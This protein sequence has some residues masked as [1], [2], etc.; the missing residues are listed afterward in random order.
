[1][2]VI[3]MSAT[4][5]NDDNVNNNKNN[6][7]KVN[8]NKNLNNNNNANKRTDLPAGARRSPREVVGPHISQ[9]A[10]NKNNNKQ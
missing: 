5:L 1:M 3:K 10:L 4:T 2:I 7:N 9:R 8:N 6:N